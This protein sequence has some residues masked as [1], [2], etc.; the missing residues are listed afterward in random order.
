MEENLK[1]EINEIMVKVL[2]ENIPIT[3]LFNLYSDEATDTAVDMMCECYEFLTYKYD[4]I[5]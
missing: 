3:N 5:S 2:L 4:F 1:S